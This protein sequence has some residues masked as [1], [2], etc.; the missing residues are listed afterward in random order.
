MA[1]TPV[2]DSDMVVIVQHHLL[3]FGT[4]QKLEGIEHMENKLYS[5]DRDEVKA[6]IKA[7]IKAVVGEG[8]LQLMD[9]H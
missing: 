9:M 2:H 3:F 7:V 6:V 4:L 1:A 8:S 5:G